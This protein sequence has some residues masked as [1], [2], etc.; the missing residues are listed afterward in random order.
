MS[1]LIDVHSLTQNKEMLAEGTLDKTI[2]EIR[3]P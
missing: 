3:S 2:F 1:I